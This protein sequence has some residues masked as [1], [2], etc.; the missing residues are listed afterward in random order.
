MW[1][2][3]DTGYYSAT[4][5]DGRMQIRARQHEDLTALRTKYAPELSE[6]IETMDADYPY[7][8]FCTAEQWGVICARIGSNVRYDNFKN[9]VY[10]TQGAQRAGVYGSIRTTLLELE[11]PE[12]D[13][14]R[15]AYYATRR[16]H[17]R[18]PVIVKIAPLELMQGDLTKDG[19]VEAVVG[20]KG[21]ADVEVYFTDG[22]KKKYRR[23]T[24]IDVLN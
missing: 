1:V 13:A 17:K 4:S 18:Q 24:K 7:R 2:M 8:A 6:T 12:T 11:T 15:K 3:T 16:P 23:S 20:I 9:N 5:K 21:T 19:E 22:S 10:A 14:K